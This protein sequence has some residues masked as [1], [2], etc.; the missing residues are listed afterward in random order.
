M[1]Y[2]LVPT[3]LLRYL[4]YF[5]RCLYFYLD[6]KEF[7]EVRV[8][9]STWMRRSSVRFMY[10]GLSENTLK[11]SSN[12]GLR[13]QCSL[14]PSIYLSIF[15]YLY[16][17]VCQSVPLSLSFFRSLSIYLSIYLSISS[18][19]HS[20]A[21]FHNFLFLSQ[22]QTHTPNC[23]RYCSCRQGWPASTWACNRTRRWSPSQAEAAL[24]GLYISF[25][26]K[27]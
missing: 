7:S 5:L 11:S 1:A 27:M 16:I 10:S 9:T 15:F 22:A 4:L 14:S 24:K 17:S 6:E 19:S 8:F 2:F 3:Q 18:Y 12:P 20:P 26:D 21:L 23:E 13:Q 25:G